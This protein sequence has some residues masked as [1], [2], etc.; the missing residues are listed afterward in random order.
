MSRKDL[1]QAYLGP[2]DESGIDEVGPI[3]KDGWELH[4]ERS[5]PPA[6]KY[7]VELSFDNKEQ[8]AHFLSSANSCL[9]SKLRTK[10]LLDHE[11]ATS[12]RKEQLGHLLFKMKSE[13]GRSPFDEVVIDFLDVLVEELGLED[14]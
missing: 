13:V 12:T 5:L 10:N 9:P 7:L 14:E 3:D 1:L 4:A 2:L 11:V 6:G 8:A